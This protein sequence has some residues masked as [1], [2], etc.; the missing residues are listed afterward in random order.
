MSVRRLGERALALLGSYGLACV[1][2]LLLLL[3]TLLGTL[4]QADHSLYAVQ[5]KYF[6]SLFVVGEGFP[7]PLPGA[8]L[9]L[10]VLFFNLLVGGMLRL[11]RARSKAGIFVIH[12]GIALMLVAGLVEFRTSH[13]GH[14]TLFEGQES[15]AFQS[16]YEWELVVREPLPDGG[17]RE[18]VVPHE[19]FARLGPGDSARFTS[20]ALPF[21]VVLAGFLPN[22]RPRPSGAPTLGVD[23]FVLEPLARAMEAESEVA[24]L[25]A[26]LDAGSERVSGLLWG[27][28]RFPWNATVA[29]RTWQVDLRKRTYDL[30]FQVHL[31]DFT[32]E[33]HPGTG[34]PSRFYS[35]V[36]CVEGGVGRDLRIS[37]NEPLR[38]GGF[39]LY[40][41]SWGPSDA[42]PGDK[43]FSTFA[44][45]Q[46][47]ADRVPLLACIVIALGLLVHFVPRLVRHVRLQSVKALSRRTG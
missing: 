11:R 47:P 25:T 41:A 13:K 1:V 22:C 8:A 17:A 45:V 39:T 18:F 7:L 4:E 19:R 2:L 3:L 23:G 28:Q 44:V 29:G 40:Q 27:L 20:D 42:R 31:R 15:G 12:V 30:P 24:G 21:D 6:E 33:L 26:T 10:T 43:L 14:L 35:D 36:T 46:N 16:Y 34:I 5:K 37:M 9:L 38:R 32:R